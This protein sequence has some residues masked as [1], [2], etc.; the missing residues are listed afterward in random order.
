MRKRS[1]PV[2]KRR[3]A[4]TLK[5]KSGWPELT[6]LI[7]VMF[8]ALMFFA[9]S[10][11]FVRIS[12]ISV[13]LPRVQAPDVADVERFVVTV[14]P[15]ETPGKPCQVYFQDKLMS[16]ELLQQHFSRLRDTSARASIIIFADRRV[17]F[18][19]VSRIMAYAE[20]AKISSFIAL[21]PP[22]AKQDTRFEQ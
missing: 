15:P 4:P 6:A 14:S 13:E 22:N 21:A 19:A 12:G 17:P 7:D 8:L 16:V 18:D 3:Y 20:A 9:L 11:S 1:T 5:P 2:G 10:G